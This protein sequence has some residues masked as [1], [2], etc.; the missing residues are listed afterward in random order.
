MFS[1]TFEIRAGGGL[2]MVVA[3]IITGPRTSS[4]LILLPFGK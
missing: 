1:L 2:N 3:A 4:L